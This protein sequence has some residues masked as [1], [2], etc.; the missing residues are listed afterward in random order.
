MNTQRCFIRTLIV[1]LGLFLCAFKASPQHQKWPG[2][3]NKALKKAELVIQSPKPDI[4]APLDLSLPVKN[5]DDGKP[6]FI[7][8]RD[9][10]QTIFDELFT[11]KVKK[12]ESPIQLK[13]GW[14][15]SPEPEVEKR[16]S[17]DGAG[18]MINFKE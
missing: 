17:V 13:G 4:K 18:I 3:A 5:L 10:E 11:A 14:I 15:H 9:P 1:I 6:D 2:T 8:A 16:K 7:D 12:P